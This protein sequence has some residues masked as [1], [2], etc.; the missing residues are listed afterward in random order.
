MDA[1]WALAAIALVL[2]SWAIFW[3]RARGRRRCPRCW[4]DM[5]AAVERTGEDGG[6][7]CPECGRRVARVRGLMSTRPPMAMGRLLDPGAGSGDRRGRLW[8]HTE[9]GMGESIAD[10]GAHRPDACCQCDDGPLPARLGARD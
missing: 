7:I 5:A 8:M 9:P 1:G 4:Y 2:F 10:A 3:D 6:F